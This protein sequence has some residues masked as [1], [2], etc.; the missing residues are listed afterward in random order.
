MRC[1]PSPPSLPP[2]PSKANLLKRVKFADEPA[3]FL[4]SELELYEEIGQFKVR[5]LPP[6]L[7]PSLLC[8]ASREPSLPPSLPSSL[9][10][11]AV[12][13]APALYPELVKLDVANSLLGLVTH[14]NTDIR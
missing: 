7:P 13:A 11:Q 14:E 5:A 8:H 9:L 3:K 10:F 12:A 4:D 6:S 1:S 2:S